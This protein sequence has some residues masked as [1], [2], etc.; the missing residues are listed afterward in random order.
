MGNTLPLI[1]VFAIAFIGVTVLL[2]YNTLVKARNMVD[3]SWSGVDVQLKRRRDL[4]PNLVST[5]QAYAV[6][7]RQT[8][9]S[10][11]EARVVAEAA[12]VGTASQAVRAE[13]ALTRTLGGLFAV[14][15]QYPDLKASQNFIQ[16]Q[17][18]LAN[19]ETNIAGARSIFNGNARDYN[20]KIQ[21]FPALLIAGPLGFS[22][23]PYFE[24]TMAERN[25]IPV[26]F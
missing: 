9:D 20:D 26:G 10:V 5:V 22:D 16:L 1:I 8:F 7:E 4:I 2:T 17:Q 23:R 19:I 18:E 25:P 15:E 21:A 14:A 11:T 12:S 13:N 3:E 24:A 6:H